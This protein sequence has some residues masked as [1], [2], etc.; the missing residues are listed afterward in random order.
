MSNVISVLFFLLIFSLLVA[1]HEGGHFLIAKANNIRVKE[2]TIGL[3]PQIFKKQK[4]ET[5]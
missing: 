5:L 2:F 4:G 1:F 3:G